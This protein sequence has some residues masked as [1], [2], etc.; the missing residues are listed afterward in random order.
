MKKNVYRYALA[1]LLVGCGT[2]RK[3]DR[4]E[5]LHA[6]PILEN[7]VVKSGDTINKIA[8]AY[9]IDPEHL[10]SINKIEPPYKIFVGQVLKVDNDDADMIVVKQI[11]YN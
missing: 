2:V 4:I 5:V 6:Q 9:S 10:V 7:Y 3:P 8:R 1:F 11:F